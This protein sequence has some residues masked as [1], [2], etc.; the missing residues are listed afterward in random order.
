MENGG[1]AMSDM[2]KNISLMEKALDASWLKNEIISDNIDN[3]DTTGYKKKTVEFERFL[4]EALDKKSFKG[5]RTHEKHIPIGAQD[6]ENIPVRIQQVGSEN[7]MRLDGNNVDVDAEMT[8][9]SKNYIYYN[10][11]IQQVSK[12]MNMIKMSI[13]DIK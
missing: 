13:R 6:S 12:Q 10:A 8:A 11:L 4:A 7:Q 3:A 2:F 9:L 1:K 5:Y